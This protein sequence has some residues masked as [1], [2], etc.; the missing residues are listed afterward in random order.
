M[1][2][3]VCIFITLY[4]SIETKFQFERLHKVQTKF[5]SIIISHES[6]IKIE[7]SWKAK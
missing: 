7:N 2:R 5:K 1:C 3:V 4:G 6:K